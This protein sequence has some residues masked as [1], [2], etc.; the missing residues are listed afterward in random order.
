LLKLGM[1]PCFAYGIAA[2]GCKSGKKNSKNQLLILVFDEVCCP[3]V[4]CI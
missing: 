3:L 4:T 2:P 1:S